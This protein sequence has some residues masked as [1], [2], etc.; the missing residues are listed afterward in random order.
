MRHEDVNQTYEE[1][2]DSKTV[3][4]HRAL[5]KDLTPSLRFETFKGN[6]G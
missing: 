4:Q 6:V 1:L 2:T 5:S 3:W